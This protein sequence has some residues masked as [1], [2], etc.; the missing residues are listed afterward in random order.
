VPDRR[1]VPTLGLGCVKLGS[2]ATGG[3][4]EGAR[5]MAHALACGVDFFDTAA[6]YGDGTSE[7]IIGRAVR[8]QRTQ[9]TIAT[10]AGYRFTERSA[11]QRAV[12][13]LLAPVLAKRARTAPP[14]TATE[15]APAVRAAYAQQDFSSDFLRASVEGSLRRLRTDYID[16]LQ[17]H[18]P[19]RVVES[20]VLETIDALVRSGKIRAFG[21]GLESLRLA[22]AW[23]DVKGLHWMQIPFGILDPQA[24]TGLIAAAQAKGVQVIVRGV[25]AAGLLA[26]IPESRALLMDPAQRQLRSEVR[27]LA[28]GAGL[29]PLALAAWYARS[30]AG[31][32][33]VLIGISSRTQL[34]ENL[35]AFSASA[36]T[37]SV[38]Q[39]LDALIRHYLTRQVRSTEHAR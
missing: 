16:I 19:P 23:L 36:P 22:E 5:L 32:D 9:V 38:M 21:V 25:F 24:G 14:V 13:W 37:A 12:R 4:A 3:S 10:K 30:H 8:S 7:R 2:V 35:A 1:D 27:A 15:R 34:D 31:V 20:D 18:G 33:V 17:L 11:A 28:G 39:Q 29:D 26:D 6:A